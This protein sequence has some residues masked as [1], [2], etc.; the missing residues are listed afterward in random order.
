MK[1]VVLV[2]GDD[3]EGLYIDGVLYRQNH[4]LYPRDIL[5]A[6]EEA[7]V[8]LMISFVKAKERWLE[9]VGRL[10]LLLKNVKKEKQ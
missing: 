1:Q 8:D 7:D 3:W 5:E 6:L 4:S 2:G 10:P 9:K